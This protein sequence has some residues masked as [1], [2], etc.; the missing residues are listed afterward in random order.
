MRAEHVSDRCSYTDDVI[1]VKFIIIRDDVP[2]NLGAN[3]IFL[4]ERITHARAEVDQKM[5]GIKKSAAATGGKSTSAIGVVEQDGLASDA[6]HEVA[7]SLARQMCR[8][9]A[10]TE[11]AADSICV[12][13]CC[14]QPG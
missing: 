1:R 7:R 12:A 9:D 6:G 2:I 13:G 14:I 4:P 5:S 10:V 11:S 3:K 8:V